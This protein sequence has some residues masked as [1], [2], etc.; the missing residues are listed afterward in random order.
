MPDNQEL[1]TGITVP[2][3]SS[4]VPQFSTAVYTNVPGSERCRICGNSIAGEYF[5]INSQM[6]CGKCAAE[7]RRGQLTDSHSAFAR[8]LLL[9]AGAALLGLIL[10]ATFT[11]VTGLYLGYVALGVGWLVGAAIKK[12]ASG[13]G[14]TR[15]QVAAVLLTYASISLASIP[16]LI[17]YSMKHHHARQQQTAQISATDSSSTSE[18][19]GESVN[20]GTQQRHINWTAAIGQLAMWGIASPFLELQ[21]PVH[22]L[23]GLVILFVGLR[24]AYR[25]T[26]AKALSVDGPYRVAG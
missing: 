19:P 12:G 26:A 17:S 16:I 25:L 6:A 9:G 7:A 1:I 4:D 18:T 23:I 3:A 24:I 14:G 8:G 11:I 10:Y 21:D 22:G 5:R 13:I 15:Y 2:P 20:A